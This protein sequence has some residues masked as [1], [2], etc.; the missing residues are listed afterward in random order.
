MKAIILAGGTGTRLWPLSRENYP[1]QFVR[2]LDGKSLFQL[3][4]ERLLVI[5]SPEDIYIVS[6]DN[7]KFHIYNQIDSL[8]IKKSIRSTL[9][10][11]VLLE[12][13]SRG[14]LLSVLFVLKYLEGQKGMNDELFF[15]FPCDHFIT[16]L[17]KFKR[18]MKKGEYLA[19]LGY[20]VTFGVKPRHLKEAYGYIITKDKLA[21]GYRVDKFV[22]KPQGRKLK[23]LFEQGALWN[24][25]IFSFKKTVF[26]E[27][28][29]KFAPPLFDFYKKSI[30]FFNRIFF[31]MP[32]SSIDYVIM[33]KTKRAA[34]VEFNL[35]WFDLGS[36]DSFLEFFS[37]ARGNI[38]LGKGEL[39]DSNN[40]FLYSKERLVVGL[41]LEDTI[42][43]DSSDA[44]LVMKKGYSDKVRK[45][46]E[47]LKSKDLKETK[48]STTVYRPW[49]Y[50]TILKR[51][52]NYK[53]KEI[54]IYPQKSISLQTHRFRSEHWNIVEGRVKITLGHKQFT[55]RRNESLFVPRGE[56]HHLYNPTNKM[57]KIIETQIGN[58]LEEDDIR[59]FDV[60]QP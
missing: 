29:Q 59:R 39:P 14:T 58:Y 45:A 27:E 60:Y 57:V 48:E 24:A 42:I 37:S 22:E 33:Q 41:G 46:V 19:S 36:W 2:F 47:I 38:I 13:A 18:F 17:G 6:N 10:N 25:G 30:S 20:I 52:D 40:C 26:L 54:G 56:K 23:L 28:L 49:G 31:R 16:P 7:Y 34:L 51:A 9:K 11:N 43:V 21:Y 53:V 32:P 44:L 55:L 5:F 15:V 8:G 12:P 1:K 35:N 4:V 3:S 50:Y